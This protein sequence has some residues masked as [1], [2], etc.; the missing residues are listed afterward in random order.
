M[1]AQIKIV[2][3]VPILTVIIFLVTLY[4]CT[5]SEKETERSKT[6]RLLT[7]NQSKDWIVDAIYFDDISQQISSCDSS[8]ILTLSSDFKWSEVFVK[9]SCYQKNTGSWSL[10]EENDVITIQYVDQLN[11]STVEREFE[12][13]EL[14]EDLFSYQFVQNN[15]IKRIRLKKK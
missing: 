13:I 7:D 15:A 14:T 8:Y 2:H 10:S 9:I 3:L 11:G 1:Y 12:L 4:G 5:K 6:I